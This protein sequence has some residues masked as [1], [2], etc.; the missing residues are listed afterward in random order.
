M[1]FDQFQAVRLFE[2]ND[3]YFQT[4]CFSRFQLICS[5]P[6]TNATRVG[7]FSTILE[8]STIIGN[9]IPLKIV[10]QTNN[11]SSDENSRHDSPLSSQSVATSNTSVNFNGTGRVRRKSSHNAIEKRYRSSINERILELK[12]IVADNDEKVQKSGV[13]RRT[14]EYI[15][16][17][18]STN[19]RLEEENRTLKTILQRLNI[20]SAFVYFSIDKNVFFCFFSVQMS[21]SF[22]MTILHHPILQLKT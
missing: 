10:A 11:F 16:Q 4:F 13:L 3:V 12:E 9:N 6:E 18:Q 14:V 21:K 2:R 1:T 19:R 20:P 8:N 22:R 17:L 5:T 15:R 7:N